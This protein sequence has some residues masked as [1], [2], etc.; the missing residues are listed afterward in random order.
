PRREPDA[1]PLARRGRLKVLLV[2]LAVLLP[3]ALMV[4][5][6]VWLVGMGQPIVRPNPRPQPPGFEPPRPIDPVTQDEFPK[7]LEEMR[8]AKN[9]PDTAILRAP[10]LTITPV[11]EEFRQEIAKGLLPGL[12]HWTFS[13]KRAAAKAL[14]VWGTPE[15]ADKLEAVASNGKEEG[16]ARAN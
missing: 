1:P 13:G 9:P 11:N 16:G 14:S 8:T 10:R 7:A 5:L 12:D 6:V 4:V 15:C 3:A 2:T